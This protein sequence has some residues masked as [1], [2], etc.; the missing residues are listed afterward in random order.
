[1]NK[2][3]RNISWIYVLVL[4]IIISF[5][6][7]MHIINV[8]NLLIC[9]VLILIYLQ[10]A[11]YH[12]AYRSDKYVKNKYPSIYTRYKNTVFKFDMHYPKNIGLQ[13]Y[14]LKED[15]EQNDMKNIKFECGMLA[16]FTIICILGLMLVNIV[17]ECLKI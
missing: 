4:I 1:M 11:N 3:Y 13:M 8:D 5:G 6:K 10:V 2:S 12:V 17:V 9:T 7:V 16:I 14:F 15:I